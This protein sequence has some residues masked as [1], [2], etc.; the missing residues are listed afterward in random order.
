MYKY[1]PILLFLYFRWMA[2]LFARNFI[3]ES[4]S[5]VHGGAPNIARKEGSAFKSFFFEGLN[6][7]NK[8]ILL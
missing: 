5:Q 6:Y 4:C 8:S 2:H 7:S 3:V 1:D